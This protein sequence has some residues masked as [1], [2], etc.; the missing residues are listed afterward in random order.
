[1]KTNT[2][3]S[4]PVFLILLT[5]HSALAFNVGD[6]RIELGVA[7]G[8][9]VKD[10]TGVVVGSAEAVTIKR[11]TTVHGQLILGDSLVVQQKGIFRP[12]TPGHD[13]RI[14][15]LRLFQAQEQVV[16]DGSTTLPDPTTGEIEFTGTTA[17]GDLLMTFRFDYMSGQ[18]P[19]TQLFTVT[20]QGTLS[21]TPDRTTFD[22]S[23]TIANATGAV[24]HVE[25]NP[26]ARDASNPVYGAGLHA[27]A[28]IVGSN[29]VSRKVTGN[30]FPSGIPDSQ[31][32]LGDNGSWL[33][34]IEDYE[35]K[36]D[37]K[38]PPAIT[39]QFLFSNGYIS[40]VDDSRAYYDKNGLH[41]WMTGFHLIDAA[42]DVGTISSIVALTDYNPRLRWK[43]N[44]DQV[45][46][47]VL[48]SD[49]EGVVEFVKLADQIPT[50]GPDG[51]NLRSWFAFGKYLLRNGGAFPAGFST[52][53]DFRMQNPP[54]GV[55]ARQPRA[56]TIIEAG[57]NKLVM[58]SG[59][60]VSDRT[61]RVSVYLSEAP[62]VTASMPEPVATQAFT[63]VGGLQNMEV[64]LTNASALFSENVT[65]YGRAVVDADGVFPRDPATQ[66]V[67]FAD[68]RISPPVISSV[69]ATPNPVCPGVAVSLSVSAS[70]EDGD[71][72][73]YT[74]DF[75][76]GSAAT[77]Q[78]VSHAFAAEGTYEVTVEVDDGRGGNDTRSVTV[79]VN[80]PVGPCPDT[81]G[82]GFSDCWETE[83]GSDPSDPGSTPFG[84]EPAG[85]PLPLQ[86]GKL[87]IKLKFNKP[88]KDS[89]LLKF[90]LPLADGFNFTGHRAIV[91]VGCV[92]R[93]FDLV[94]SKKGTAATGADRD[95][96]I[97][98]KKAKKGF[99]K[100]IFRGKKGSF[101]TN[102][103]DS[104]GLENA[105]AKRETRM[106]KLTVLFDL[107][108]HQADQ[109]V[110]WNAKLDKNSA[111]TKL[112]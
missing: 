89:I 49:L 70:D 101:A 25:G 13:F 52:T 56:P 44:V 107:K 100:V 9:V 7:G 43:V 19:G 106:V 58:S 14:A 46:G 84:S 4:L 24:I 16:P 60:D 10:Q 80:V 26:A 8:M 83:V 5:Q 27:R 96:T 40:T 63:S 109:Q 36:E 77:G 18:N 102:L 67:L 112:K 99:S 15:G 12:S 65:L 35:T 94:P 37:V 3:I 95:C 34:H 85:D 97:K 20:G 74:W 69:N 17:E 29:Y 108:V 66:D 59:M 75:K 38:T 42:E 105:N 50:D 62:L 91:D 47:S 28:L 87:K 11:R 72:L 32:G 86:V 78:S 71:T 30:N 104:S 41:P 6:W 1:M 110:R 111:A 39:E 2:F 64:D 57:R 51:D 31:K 98:F 79:V 103:S 88:E 82:D 92:I 33:N 55:S 68:F 45:T 61:M 76:D 48:S 53:M 21:T 93:V 81:D 90:K 22:G 73:S 54:D 23:I